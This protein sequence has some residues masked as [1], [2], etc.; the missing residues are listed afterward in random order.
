MKL[1]KKVYNHLM[2]ALRRHIRF[3]I[4]LDDDLLLTSP[5]EIKL[6]NI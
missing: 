1:T 3:G 6:D 2:E 4:S 5:R